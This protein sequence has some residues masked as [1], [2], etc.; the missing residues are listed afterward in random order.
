MAA[1]GPVLFFYVMLR[2]ALLRAE[3]HD[4]ALA[5]YLGA[6]LLEFGERDR[7]WRVDWN[8]D[9]LHG[10]LV[11]IVADL[12][13]TTGERRFRVM[14]HLGEYA[15]WMAGLF[16]QFIAA[17]QRRGGPD[18]GYY[19]ALGRRGYGM[20]SDHVLA[21]RVGLEGVYRLAA[22]R[23]GTL[24]GALNGVSDRVFFPH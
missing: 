8:D 18:V 2:H 13:A 16:P 23:F 1:P 11:D 20:A 6:M 17:R 14:V 19:E 7:A 9:H 3:V 21:D 15:L 4:R 22:E 24:R 10:Y 5:D 12:E